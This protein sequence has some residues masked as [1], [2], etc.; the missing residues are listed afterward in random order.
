MRNF[1]AK[2]SKGMGWELNSNMGKINIDKGKG[3][4]K[5]KWSSRKKTQENVLFQVSNEENVSGRSESKAIEFSKLK[6][7]SWP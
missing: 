4:K 1:A 2:G 5:E 3:I 7:D 6:C